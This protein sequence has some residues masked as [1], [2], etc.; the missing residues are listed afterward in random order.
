MTWKL[1]P[2]KSHA[3]RWLALAAQTDQDIVLSGMNQAGQD[4]ISMRRCL[5]QMGVRIVDLASNGEALLQCAQADLQPH[6]GTS[7]WKIFGVGP[8]GLRAPVSVLHAG[9]SGTTLRILMALAALQDVPIML[10]GDASLRSR[11]FSTMLSV[12]KQG[13]VECSYG[14]A[15]ESLPLLVRGPFQ[16]NQSIHIDVSKSSQPTTA[17]MLASPNFSSAVEV[18]PQGVAVSRKHADLTHRMCIWAGASKD[19]D[20]LLAP[21]QPVFP[22]NT[23]EMPRDCSM[24]AFVFLAVKALGVQVDVDELPARS[25]S[26][27][28]EILFD[29]SSDLGINVN[30]SSFSCSESGVT[31]DIDL[32]DANDLITPLAALLALGHGG[33]ILGAQHAAY[34][35]TNRLIG[36][37]NFLAQFGLVLELKDG[38]FTIDGGQ[39]LQTPASIVHTFGDHRMQLTAV[40]LALATKNEVRIDGPSL[41]TVADP[42]ALQRWRNVGVSIS[43]ELH[44]P[45]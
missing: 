39:V 4:I 19:I 2:S 35:E 36:T 10:D 9:N 24:L 6:E 29:F 5:Q 45:W 40:I 32:R 8:R 20:A 28:H 16:P 30:G 12:L 25:E 42:E 3:I 31:L 15:H 23:I 38:Q 43:E 11:S 18:H 44:Q 7:S 41:H 17:W 33:C 13:S 22:H 26:L 37:K 34:K 27:G 21:W 14:V 1:P